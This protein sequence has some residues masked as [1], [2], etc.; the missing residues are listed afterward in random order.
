LNR[1]LARPLCTRQQ[2][3][4]AATRETLVKRLPGTVRFIGRPPAR[5]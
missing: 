1:W 5:H 2:Q 4:A 3:A